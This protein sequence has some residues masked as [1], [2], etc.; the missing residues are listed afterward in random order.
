MTGVKITLSGYVSG[1]QVYGPPNFGETP[2]IDE[3]RVIP[4]LILDKPI[5]VCAGSDEEIDDSPVSE[6]T[7]IQIANY[8]AHALGRNEVSLSGVL[9]RAQNA[10]HYTPV[11]F[12]AD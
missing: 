8:S 4:V 9:E 3:K 5:S 11:F 6:V 10:Y 7:E 1:R 12:I 2:K